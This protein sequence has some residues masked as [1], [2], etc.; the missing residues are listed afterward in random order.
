MQL[1]ELS[2]IVKNIRA[3]EAETVGLLEEILQN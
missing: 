2:D 1:R 3:L